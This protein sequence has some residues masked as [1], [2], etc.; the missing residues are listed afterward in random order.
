MAAKK[1]IIWPLNTTIQAQ[2]CLLATKQNLAESA[3]INQYLAESANSLN[4]FH[5]PLMGS[6]HFTANGSIWN[7]ADL[8]GKFRLGSMAEKP[9]PCRGGH[10]ILC[11][12]MRLN[13]WFIVPGP[14][15]KHFDLEVFRAGPYLLGNPSL[16]PLD[17]VMNTLHHAQKLLVVRSAALWRSAHGFLR[18]GAEVAAATVQAA[19][20]VVVP[21]SGRERHAQLVTHTL[22]VLQR[23]WP[24][25]LYYL[26]MSCNQIGT[27]D[28]QRLKKGSD[29]ILAKGSRNNHA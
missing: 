27:E 18:V 13:K 26:I 12:T 8:N 21:L 22:A 20:A 15:I 19:V 5:R 24:L 28:F 29:A 4:G 2:T 9:Y 1:G 16:A 14:A 7:K 25:F 17:D 10:F 3:R 23:A 6:Q 11:V